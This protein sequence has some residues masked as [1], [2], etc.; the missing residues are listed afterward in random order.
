MRTDISAPPPNLATDV[1]ALRNNLAVAYEELP[2]DEAGTLNCTGWSRQGDK[3]LAGGP[4]TCLRF[5]VRGT[6]GTTEV[7]DYLSSAYTLSNGLCDT[8]F[9]SAN[10][11]ALHRNNNRANV[12]DVGTLVSAIL[13]LSGAGS[14]ATSLSAALTG[15]GDNV[16]RNYDA[17]YLVDPDLTTLRQLVHVEQERVQSIF[18]NDPPTTFTDASNAAR[19]YAEPCSYLGMKRLLTEA[20]RAKARTDAN[21]T[22]ENKDAGRQP[23]TPPS[24]SAAPVSLLITG[25]APESADVSGPQAGSAV[26]PPSNLPAAQWGRSAE[27]DAWTVAVLAEVRAGAGRIW[28]ASFQPSDIG[29]FCP[30]YAKATE[31]ERQAFWGGLVSAIAAQET[32]GFDPRAEFTERDGTVS[33]GLLQLTPPEPSRYDCGFLTEGNVR[34]AIPNL[35]CGVRILAYQ[36][37][38]DGVIASGTDAA[39]ARGAARY[40]GPMRRAGRGKAAAWTAAQDYCRVR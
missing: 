14:V 16:I 12:N 2:R 25:A 9:R 11:A 35:R 4:K 8:F 6:P 5:R 27:R 32:R 30:G 18:K 39:T 3:V 10:A 24:A 22:V 17:S 36:V 33:V 23:G 7:E 26:A 21:Q 40:W 1:T 31:E 37:E 20:M 29:D 13:G 28:A 15:F 34:E 38:R 19:I